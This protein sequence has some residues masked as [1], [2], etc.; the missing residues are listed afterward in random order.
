MLKTKK[1]LFIIILF[2]LLFK[3]NNVFEN[4]KKIKQIL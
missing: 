1:R 3:I 2:Q 4:I